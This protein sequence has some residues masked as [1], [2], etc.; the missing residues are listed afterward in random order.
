MRKSELIQHQQ[1]AHSDAEL[2]D[3]VEFKVTVPS[4]HEDQTLRLPVA[5]S[6][7]RQREP[8]DPSKIQ[9]ALKAEK[10]NNTM[11]DADQKDALLEN[12][13][14]GGGTSQSNASSDSTDDII[15]SSADANTLY[16]RTTP[17]IISTYQR[18]QLIDRVMEMFYARSDGTFRTIAHGSS[19]SPNGSQTTA[20]D[21]NTNT[22]NHL[23]EGNN[24]IRRGGQKRRWSDSPDDDNDDGDRPRKPPR[25][26]VSFDS[27]ETDSTK[28]FACPYYKRD[29][30][31][32]QKF[33]TCPG[34]GWEHIHRMK[35]VSLSLPE[36][37]FL[38]NDSENIYI[39]DMPC[40]YS[41]HDAS[42]RSKPI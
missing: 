40:Q 28:K 36:I 4:S 26:P 10:F 18:R 41:A 35:Y 32:Y 27:H 31:R 12:A 33:T 22:Q 24:S 21:A 39:G 42:S 29:P 11:V 5:D 34:P 19:S 25:R 38:A 1:S 13:A 17:T 23:G 30:H 2:Q 3:Q 7:P 15:I 6:R 20:T 14:H 37:E 16:E 9:P 8:H